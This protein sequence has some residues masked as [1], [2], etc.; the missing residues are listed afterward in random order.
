VEL[1]ITNAGAVDYAAIPPRPCRGDDPIE[2]DRT[3]VP[4]HGLGEPLSR[5]LWR[6]RQ[7]AVTDQE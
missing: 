5:I 2:Y 7:W 6:G 3:H 1:E 4:L